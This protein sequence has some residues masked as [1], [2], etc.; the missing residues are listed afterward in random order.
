MEKTN[1]GLRNSEEPSA[2]RVSFLVCKLHLKCDVTRAEKTDFVF[3]AKR[4][5]PFKSAS[6]RHFSRLVSTEVC[7]SAVEMLDTPCSEVVWR[8]LATHCIRQSRTSLPLRASPCAITLQ[9]ESTKPS[10][11]RRSRLSQVE[12]LTSV[13]DACV[14][15]FP[16]LPTAYNR[17]WRIAFR[18]SSTRNSCQTHFIHPAFVTPCVVIIWWGS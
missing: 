16:S 15:D 10:E 13:E 8:V 14:L 11:W 4:K 18:N 9:L 2:E 17:P 3:A 7:A 5:S 6:G 12:F 1:R